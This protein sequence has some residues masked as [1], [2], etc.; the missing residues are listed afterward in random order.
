M[1]RKVLTSIALVLAGISSIAQDK[2][3]FDST[4]LK[5]VIILGRLSP[6]AQPVSPGKIAIPVMDLPQSIS[7]VDKTIIANQ[8][9]QRLSDVMK[10]VNGV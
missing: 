6:N 2:K 9:A 7:I 5:E 4:E 1:N 3:P 10:N 8:Q